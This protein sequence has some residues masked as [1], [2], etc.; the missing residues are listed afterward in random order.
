MRFLIQVFFV[1]S[2]A[3]LRADDPD[4]RAPLNVR[5][6][7]LEAKMLDLRMVMAKTLIDLEEF[8]LHPPKSSSAKEDF[9]KRFK[10]QM[11]YF[12]DLIHEFSQQSIPRSNFGKSLLVLV[13]LQI[14]YSSLLDKASEK[15]TFFKPFYTKEHKKLLDFNFQNYDKDKLNPAFLVRKWMSQSDLY[16][17]EGTLD[18]VNSYDR[19]NVLRAFYEQRYRQSLEKYGEGYGSSKPVDY[20]SLNNLLKVIDEPEKSKLAV[21][22]LITKQFT[23]NEIKDVAEGL[24]GMSGLKKVMKADSLILKGWQKDYE[25]R[26][27]LSFYYPDKNFSVECVSLLDLVAVRVTKRK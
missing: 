9:E 24:H 10:H 25:F 6:N 11:G 4:D 26:R 23:L 21:S 8:K 7:I 20:E 14:R 18:L 3:Q 27:F 19:F 17:P 12:A 2:L 1:L 15:S 16:I 13:G 5:E 22:M